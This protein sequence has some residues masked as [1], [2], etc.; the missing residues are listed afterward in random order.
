MMCAASDQACIESV[1]AR[2]KASG[3]VGI[4]LEIDE[5][6]GVYTVNKVIAG[7]P[8][9]KAGIKPKDVLVEINGVSLSAC[10]DSN[11]SETRRNWKPGQ[12]VTYTIKRDGHD[13]EITLT[14]ATMPADILARYIAMH[15]VEHE[16]GKAPS[17]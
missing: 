6:T 3:W 10:K 9:A 11:L 17:P 7:S 12:S 14:L 4:E 13:R 5:G 16:T 1:A 8:A 2:M 15:I